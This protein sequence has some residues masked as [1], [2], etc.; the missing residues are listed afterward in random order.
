MENRFPVPAGFE[1][2]A[3]DL[4]KRFPYQFDG[5]RLGASVPAGWTDVFS[6]LCEDVDALLGEDKRGFR[7]DQVKEKW[8]SMRAY[9]LLGKLDP[10]QRMDIMSEAPGGDAASLIVKPKAERR[11]PKDVQE[12]MHKLRSVILE[13]EEQSKKLCPVC[14]KPS[15]MGTHDGWVAPLCDEH[16]AALKEGRDVGK[17]WI[18]VH[19]GR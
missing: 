4:I 10:D 12:L 9:F 14:G 5:C 16:A 19:P 6:K 2:Y 8:G 3:E 17:F 7:W 15:E 11:R 18:V 1:R 13:A